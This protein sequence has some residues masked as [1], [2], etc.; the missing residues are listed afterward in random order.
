M[1]IPLRKRNGN[2]M[3]LKLSDDDFSNITFDLLDLEN[4]L[5]V[6]QEYKIHR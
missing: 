1:Y 4:V 5:A 6:K 2:I 3:L